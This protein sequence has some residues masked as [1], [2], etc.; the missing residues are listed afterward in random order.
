MKRSN[1]PRH[2]M[3]HF[4][5]VRTIA[6]LIC[7]LA[8]TLASQRAQAQQTTYIESVQPALVA[9]WGNLDYNTVDEAWAALQASDASN[10]GAGWTCTDDN[11]HPCLAGEGPQAYEWGQPE[12]YCWHWQR[13]SPSGHTDQGITGT[14]GNVPSCPSRP[15]GYVWTPHSV[16]SGHYQ[17]SCQLTRTAIIPCDHCSGHGLQDAND[18][19]YQR[20]QDYSSGDGGLTFGRSYDSAYGRFRSGYDP[21]FVPPNQDSGNTS[22]SGLVMIY[23]YQVNYPNGGWETFERN[24]TILNNSPSSSNAVFTDPTGARVEMSWDGTNGSSTSPFFKDHLTQQT[25]SG[26][27]QWLLLRPSEDRLLGFDS[28]GHM[29]FSQRPDGRKTTLTY[30]SGALSGVSDDFGHALT[31]SMGT[32]GVSSI[33]DPAGNSISYSYTDINKLNTITYQDSSVKSY[34]WDEST[35]STGSAAPTDM[36][37]GI[38]DE[39]TTR[40][41]SF[42]YSNGKAVST[43]YSGGAN[44]FSISDP[45]NPYYGTGNITETD[46]LGTSRID[47]YALVNGFPRLSQITQPDSSGSGTT[48]STISYDSV[49][50]PASRQ[51]FNGNLTC[52]K[53][54]ST[55]NLETI[56][57][58]GFASGASCPG[59]L[60]TYTASAPRR[61]ITTQY[62]P[63]WNLPSGRAEPNRIT[64]WVYNGQP[65]PTAG[66]A[67]ASCVPSG[68]T[69]ADGSAPAVVCKR[70]LQTTTDTTGSQ[71]FS[72]TTTG[73]PRIWTYTYNAYGQVLTAQGPR[74]DVT[75]TTTYAYYSCT[76]G[77]QC[78]E[79]HT[80]TDPVGNVTTYNTYNAHGQ[81]LTITDPNGVVTTLTYDTRQRLTSRQVGSETT[82]FT[83]WPTGLLK[84][85]T[86][87]DSSY[88]Q[89]SYDNAHR[90][91]QIA[92]GAGNSIQYTLDAMGNRTA[93]KSY[94]PS[95]TLHRTHT[96]VFSSLNNLYQDINA[97]NTSAVTTNYGFD[98]ERNQTSISAPLSR[99]TTNVFDQLNRLKQVTDPGS[100]NTYFGYD[101]NDDL[102]S[103]QDPLG[104]STTYSYNGF[105]DLTQL[106]SPDTGTSGNS[107]DSGGN[108]SVATDARG[109]NAHYSYDAAN[110]VTSIVYKDS[111]GTT[112]Q[113]LTLGYDSGTYGKGRL[114][115][116]SDANHSLSWTYDAQGRVVG[117]GVTVGT[118][119]LSVGYGYSNGNMT[120]ITTPSGQSVVYGYNSNHQVTGITVNSTAVL[121]G[122]TYEPFGAVNGW[123]WGNSSTTRR[124][125]NGDGLISQIVAAGVTLGYS[126]D[127]ANRI[128]GISDSSDSTLSWSYG[129]DTLDRALSPFP[130]TPT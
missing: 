30:T 47:N 85:V 87:P 14:I 24:F 86:L 75:S 28:T 128:T 115:T 55:R 45:R 96:R 99:N 124:S 107:Y 41:A 72:A 122:V 94:D 31:V 100:G 26:S 19:N 8:F 5:P 67:T 70:I 15:G 53:Y 64:T 44:Q 130:L 62:H 105:G 39:S 113:T 77:T 112:D 80:V 120:A 3:P 1:A 98:N 38:V 48:T 7:V 36:L 111:G 16:G 18:T 54:D 95:S 127:N 66:G 116:A 73:S 51:D 89:Y 90:L 2:V 21:A 43:Q 12:E 60:S 92:D 35:L 91:S 10:C 29:L 65:D 6:A 69:L 126:F 104:N 57:V 110:R 106:V 76:T 81:P 88:V 20:E 103:V 49:G 125:F 119:T 74:T 61:K 102:A 59:N 117:K 68:T 83:Y 22:I 97:A 52:Y 71:G 101:G 46:P 114:T 93:E 129:F 84:K 50:N 82:G 34:V 32:N 42:G 118:V 9:N 58:E 25:V 17:D 23:N 40:F 56:R 79:L 121:S 109:A 123:T 33:T 78:G 27:T 37:T 13:V 4:F 63:T 11:L 108:L